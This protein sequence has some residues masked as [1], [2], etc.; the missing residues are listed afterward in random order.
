M[1]ERDAIRRH[2]AEYVGTVF[3][4]AL[5]SDNTMEVEIPPLLV[6]IFSLMY[7]TWEL[8]CSWSS[9]T[10]PKCFTR[11]YW[12]L[13]LIVNRGITCCLQCKI[14]ALVLPTEKKSPRLSLAFASR[15]RSCCVLRKGLTPL[16]RW[17]K[18]SAYGSDS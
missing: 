9:I 13:S 11:F 3:I 10:T 16:E 5:S 6:F 8:I 1:D 12:L 15:R 17:T 14:M 7:L 18:S 4:S 2:G